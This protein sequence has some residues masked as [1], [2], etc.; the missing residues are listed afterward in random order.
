MQLDRDKLDP[1]YVN[2]RREAFIILA[3]WATC[4]VYT[5]T[6][7]RLFGYNLPPEQI[8]ITFGMPSWV[9]YGVL[10]PWIA[11]GVFSIVYSLFFMTDDDLGEEQSDV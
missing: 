5:V 6:Y 9:F 4:L 11:A 8:T 3:V 7:C 1:V 10:L 2:T